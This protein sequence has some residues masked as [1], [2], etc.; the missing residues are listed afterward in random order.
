MKNQF[1]A[2]RLHSFENA[3][4]GIWHLWKKEINFRIH[5]FAGILVAAL[6][7]LVEITRTKWMMIIVCV[8][9]VLGA[10]AFNSAI[11]R[12]CDVVSPEKNRQIKIIKDISAA[13]VLIVS[14]MAAIIALVIFC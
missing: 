6:G 4:N 14:V 13:A 12:I 7:W 11:E 3:L 5:I 9:I 2:K 8:G 1:L 10:E